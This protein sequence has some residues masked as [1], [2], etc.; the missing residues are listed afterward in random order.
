MTPN[1][2]NKTLN[3]QAFLEFNQSLY[4]SSV[5]L[6]SE[7][8][9]T[10]ISYDTTRVELG[11]LISVYVQVYVTNIT[12]QVHQWFKLKNISIIDEPH[13]T[14]S[15][16]FTFWNILKWVWLKIQKSIFCVAY[17][18]KKLQ[19]IKCQVCHALKLRVLYCMK[20]MKRN[21]VHRFFPQKTNQT[22]SMLYSENTSFIENHNKSPYPKTNRRPQS[23]KT[24]LNHS[25]TN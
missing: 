2:S 19:K 23:G 11:K 12:I 18:E 5:F 1:V 7:Q 4:I 3:C 6:Q 9:L 15:D 14:N 21:I 24:G 20:F 25:S 16:W 13:S 17:M 22:R 10:L 8:A